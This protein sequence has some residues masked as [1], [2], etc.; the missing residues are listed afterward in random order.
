MNPRPARLVFL[1]AP[2]ALMLAAPAAAAPPALVTDSPVTAALAQ[3]VIGDLGEAT[4]LLDRNADPHDFQFR[5]SQARQLQEAGLLIWVGPE[6]TPWLSEAAGQLDE[7]RRLTLLHLPETATRDFAA[8]HDHEGHAHVDHDHGDEDA[9]A[10]TGETMLDPHAWLDP[11]NGAAWV[12]AIAERLSALDPENAA[13]YR[14]NA[15]AAQQRIARLDATLTERL[16]AL[17]ARPFVTGHDA[18]G[19]FTKHFG[20]P[21][22]IPVALGDATAPSAARLTRIRDEIAA[23][24]AVCAFPEM[25]QSPRLLATAIEGTGLRMGE[26][27]SPNGAERK[28][29]SNAYDDL[30]TGLAERIIACETEEN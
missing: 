21:D 5:P 9:S 14:E 22:A 26:L 7:S 10:E 30:L 3:Q 29:G 11:D 17:P 1:A 8:G 12:G 25:A 28:S 13:T 19:Y 27:L 15:G 16:A 24:G 18:Y 4:T 2:L 23:S 6:L 20:L